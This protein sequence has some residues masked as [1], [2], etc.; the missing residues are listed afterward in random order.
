MAKRD[1]QQGT[2]ALMLLRTLEVLGPLHGYGIARRIEQISGDLLAV[3]QGTLY[4]VLLKLEQEGAIASEWGASDNN[5]RARFYRLTAAGRRRLRVEAQ[6]WAQTTALDEPLPRSEGGGPGMRALRR[7]VR[8][9][10]ASVL[11]RRDDDRI[12][13]ELS[14]HLAL[15]TEEHVRAGLP[16]DEARRRASIKLGTGDVTTEA[17][18][19]EQRLR[20]LEDLGWD[21]RYTIRTLVKTPV[22]TVVVVLTLALGIGA[23]TAIFS[24]LNGLLL[25]TLPVHEPERLV[26]ITDSIVG[27]T[28]EVRVR[29]WSYPAWEQIRQRSHLFEAATA[30]SFARFNM[31]SGGE[32]RVR[33]RHLGG[34]RIL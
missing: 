28:G 24:I 1:V 4:P 6:E 34:R 21:L 33:R 8:R 10:T 11:G 19:D 26:H 16:L 15:L 27:D 18:R 3:N 23:N 22:F 5:R 29:A 13:A 25:R 7:F 14:E 30:W 12:R 31:A 32:T 20:W 2:L 9:L 17:Y